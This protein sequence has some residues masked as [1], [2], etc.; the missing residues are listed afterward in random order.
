MKIKKLKILFYSYWPNDTCNCYMYMLRSICAILHMR[1]NEDKDMT[2]SSFLSQ[3]DPTFEI[4]FLNPLYIYLRLE[5]AFKF[6]SM[7]QLIIANFFF[8]ID[9]L[10]SI[11]FLKSISV[12]VCFLINVINMILLTMHKATGRH[13]TVKA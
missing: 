8:M 3:M 13:E 4:K 11:A 5:L 12:Q 9:S 7:E 2:E 10:N 6:P 1:Y